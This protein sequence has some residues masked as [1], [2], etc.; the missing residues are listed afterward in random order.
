MDF[1]TDRYPEISTKIVKRT[2]RASSGTSLFSILGEQQ[3]IPRL[4]KKFMNVGSNKK[5]LIDFLVE[6]WKKIPPSSLGSVKVFVTEDE[7]CFKIH[8]TGNV[9]VVA[10]EIP[11]L[12]SAFSLL[13]K[14]L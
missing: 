6:E 5:G 9:G 14:F 4:W 13:R 8:S 1:V 7:K 12:R 10:E 3:R 11:E 2:S